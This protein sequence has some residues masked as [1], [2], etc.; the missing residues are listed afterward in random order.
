VR[1]YTIAAPFTSHHK[2][3]NYADPKPFSSVKPACFDFSSVQ[4]HILS[5]TGDA[6]R[7]GPRVRTHHMKPCCMHA[8]CMVY[9]NCEM[10]LIG[11][12]MPSGRK[13]PLPSLEVIACLTFKK[14]PPPS[15]E[16]HCMPY[17]HQTHALPHHC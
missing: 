3:S 1:V 2:L 9:D 7:T 16:G 12:L 13:S 5:T 15:L 10:Y 8:H 4:D 17:F 14:P 11:S 6:L